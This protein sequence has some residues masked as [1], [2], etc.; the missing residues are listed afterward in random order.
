[1]VRGV[2]QGSGLKSV[3]AYDVATHG[4]SAGMVL[5]PTPPEYIGFFTGRVDFCKNLM[6]MGVSILK[7]ARFSDVKLNDIYMIY[8]RPLFYSQ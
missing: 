7:L 3:V 4:I 2:G 6:V 8:S 1:M 5:S